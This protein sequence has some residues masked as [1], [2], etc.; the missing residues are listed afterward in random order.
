[1]KVATNHIRDIAKKISTPS[2]TM[3]IPRKYILEG[4]VV[5]H[6]T[7]HELKRKKM[8]GIMFKKDFENSYDKVKM[9]FL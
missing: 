9:A 4:V 5:L 3:F 7:I 8:N 2:E 1:M 6:K